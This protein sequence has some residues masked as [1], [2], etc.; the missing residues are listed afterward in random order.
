MRVNGAWALAA[1]CSVMVRNEREEEGVFCKL[2]MHVWD[3]PQDRVCVDCMQRQVKGSAA[4]ACG[5][6]M[7]IIIHVQ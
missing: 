4:Q 5:I 6:I 1:S 2:E 3:P 7:I